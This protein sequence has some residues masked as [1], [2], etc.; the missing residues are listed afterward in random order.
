M[1]QNHDK[2]NH[3]ELRGIIEQFEID[4]C[5]FKAT[6]KISD[7]P[8]TWA[9]DEF[10]DSKDKDNDGESFLYESEKEY[11]EDVDILTTRKLSQY[12]LAKKIK[13]AIENGCTQFYYKNSMTELPKPQ[14]TGTESQKN[15]YLM[16]VS[17]RIANKLF[18]K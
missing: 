13:K 4:S 15:S 8:E 11:K 5:I 12:E 18:R 7:H 14:R 6:G 2:I 1:I 10:R 9:I 17:L 16:Q 3:L